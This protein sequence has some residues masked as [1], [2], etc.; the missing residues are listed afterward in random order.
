MTKMSWGGGDKNVMGGV[1]KKS[2]G[3]GDKNVTQRI[4]IYK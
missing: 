1:T 2:W 4:H 3:G